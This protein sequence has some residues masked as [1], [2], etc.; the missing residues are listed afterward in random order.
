MNNIVNTN[1]II[2]SINNF[3]IVQVKKLISNKKNILKLNDY[4]FELNLKSKNIN[5]IYL[6]NFFSEQILIELSSY[7]NISIISTNGTILHNNWVIQLDV[8][9]II[10]FLC[11]KYIDEIIKLN[12]M[13][14][15]P[16][17]KHNSLNKSLN[18]KPRKKNIPVA[19]KRKVWAKWIGEEIGK[20]KCL[21]CKLTEITQLNFSCGH[22][23]AEANG[24][25]LTIENLRPICTSCNSSMG[26]QNFNDFINT[27]GL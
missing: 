22:V 6:S 20:T 5:F 16:D 9:K 23:V 27:Y 4:Y 26:T 18:P 25:T 3:G 7:L 17:I 12:N 8:K 11:S 2:Q 24:G 21:C 13:V 14:Y 10:I 1:F 19:L 15:I